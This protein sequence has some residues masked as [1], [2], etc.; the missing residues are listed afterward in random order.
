MLC[1]VEAEEFCF[2]V[3]SKFHSI[4]LAAILIFVSIEHDF[5]FRFSSLRIS[6]PFSLSKFYYT[7]TVSRIILRL[8]S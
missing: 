8:S 3:D 1:V 5:Q 7:Q 2:C 4:P 6:L